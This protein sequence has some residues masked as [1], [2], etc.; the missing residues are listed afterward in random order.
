[1]VESEAASSLATC[2]NGGARGRR[3]VSTGDVLILTPGDV[4]RI[5]SYVRTKY[6]SLPGERHAE[7]VADAVR[8]AI[9][10]QLPAFDA[11][12]R[13][14]LT[15]ALIR[16]VVLAGG[17]PVA[18]ADVLEQIMRLDWRN[19]DRLRALHAWAAARLGAEPGE[20]AL[21]SALAGAANG[22]QA[23]DALRQAAEQAAGDGRAAAVQAADAGSLV[24]A[25]AA[26]AEHASGAVVVP[27]PNRPSDPGQPDE[28]A[29]PAR[30][31]YAALAALLA[32][33]MTAYGL[34]ADF[35]KADEPA[36]ALPAPVPE[37]MPRDSALTPSASRVEGNELPARLRWREVDA[38]KLR[39]YLAARK[40]LLRHEPYFSTIMDAAYEF[41]IHP[42]LLFA[43]T[44]QEQGFV[45]EDHPQAETIANN[46]F[47][48]YHSWQEFNTT[49]EHSA[50]VAARTIIRLSRD[51][52]A[53]T[54]PVEWINREYA[55][56]PLW[57]RG[58][59]ALFSAMEQYLSGGGEGAEANG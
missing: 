35:G 5:R 6:A 49:T 51:R 20:Q 48:V 23:W 54:D 58:V 27:F 44:G 37:T 8:R 36:P 7:I 30:W 10:R 31:H 2:I 45:P 50:A 28:P 26:A 59:N 55:E 57:H 15:D 40:S 18:A 16:H 24:P 38:D 32:V 25:S 46:P 33:G 41:D 14:R 47:N 1:M 17:R 42:L 19:P 13:R 22:L 52:P 53:G 29:R 56:D 12:L 21:A 3:L 4:G 39:E 34:A 43:I 9:D 11:Q